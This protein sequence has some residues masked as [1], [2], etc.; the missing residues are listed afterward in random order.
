MEPR[1]ILTIYYADE[2]QPVEE[3]HRTLAKARSRVADIQ[4][5]PW[6]HPPSFELSDAEGNEVEL[7]A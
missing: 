7:T 2:R 5:M 1:Y 4:S 3:E 6:H